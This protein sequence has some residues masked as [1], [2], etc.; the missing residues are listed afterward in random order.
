MVQ[1]VFTVPFAKNGSRTAIPDANQPSGEVSY[2]TGFGPDYE[3]QLGVDP[4]AKNIE[5]EDFNQS[6]FDATQALQEFQAGLGTVPFNA[7]LAA[8]LSPAGYPKGAIIPRAEFDG[9]WISTAANNSTDPTAGGSW[10]PTSVVG[11]FTQALTNVN[12]TISVNNAA[13][14]RINL[15]GVLTAN[16]TVT[17]PNWVYNWDVTN[18]CT[19]AFTVTLKTAA[20]TGIV[21]SQ[22]K[23]SAIFG[24]GT[25]I[26]LRQTDFISPALLVSPT[27]PTPVPGDDSTLVSTTAFVKAAIAAAIAAAIGGPG[28][29]NWYATMTPPTGYLAATGSPIPRAAFPALFSAITAAAT[30]TVTSGSP[31][32]TA[33]PST[34]ALWVGMP[35]SGPGIPLSATILSI[36]ANTSITLSINAT[37][38]TAGA[39]LAICPFGVGDGSTTFNLPDM[40]GRVARGH[41][42]GIDAGRVF[43]SLQAGQNAIHN[44]TLTDPGHFHGLSGAGGF[45]TTMMGGGSNTYALWTSGNTAS[46][47]TGITLADSGGTEARMMNIAL[48]PCIKF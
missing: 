20:G 23:A 25:N 11:S 4:L 47:A 6:L 24:D 40:R 29:I 34:N 38:T 3:R 16:V 37:A 39:T 28:I 35:I 10:Q 8:A 44:H 48:L 22:G 42:S 12:V 41:D 21:V 46:K 14:P 9:F 18:N 31:T 43:G 5:R 33:V 26:R 27:A 45:G 30:G 7:T 13:Y 36:V 17:L 19:G 1:K 2:N 32:I 15:S